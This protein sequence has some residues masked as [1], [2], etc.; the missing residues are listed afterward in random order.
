MECPDS[1]R[2]SF[3][4][5][6]KEAFAIGLLTKAEG[7]QVTSKQELHT[8]LK[9]AY[10]LTVVHKW[11]GAPPEVVAQA[12]LACKKALVN[13]YDFCHAENQ[14]RDILCAEIMQLVGQVKNLFGVELSFLNSDKGSFIPDSY[15]HIED[16]SVSFTLDGFAKVMQKFK[17]YHASLCDIPNS[18]CKA[19]EDTIDGARLCIT[20]LG[21]TI[22][23]LNTACNTKT[24]KVSKDIPIG[25]EQ[26]QR[27]SNSPAVNPELSTTVESTDALGSSWEKFS[28]S[29]TGSSWPST[30]GNTGSGANEVGTNVKNQSCMTTDVDDEES[31]SMLKFT[32]KNEKQDSH[33]LNSVASTHTVPRSAGPAT[34]SFNVSRD[35]EKFEAIQAETETVSTEEGW[36]NVGGEA[37][38]PPQ[39]L[40]QLTLRT[41]TSSLSD[42]FSSQSS[43]EKIS[44]DICS[45]TARKPQSSNLSNAGNGQIS[46]SPESDGSFFLV[47]T[48]DP[49]PS[50]ATRDITCKKP[51]SGWE[52]KASS[53]QQPLE[54]LNVDPNM[55]TEFDSV[56]VKPATKNSSAASHQNLFQC[57]PT[58]TSTESS[59]EMLEQNQSEHQ[60]KEVSSAE[61]VIVLQKK[62]PSCYSCLKHSIV[63]SV[64]P[65][66]QYL[67]SQEDYQ[68]LLAGICQD[69]LLNRLK[70]DTVQF[71]LKEHRMVYSEYDLIPFLLK[72][73]F[74]IH[75]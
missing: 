14:D 72:Y 56:S 73:A 19:P 13:F 74:S 15:R 23:T 58:E 64:V 6:A 61:K 21:T 28:L 57:A 12:T 37:Q 66:Q 2:P 42:S 32:D 67:L 41:S 36:T 71:K 68:A 1:Q 30:N 50:D 24:C 65:E 3:L 35:S 16:I 25:E 7:E 8:F 34:S 75:L 46:K 47:K 22:G 31:D 48:L 5:L 43:W 27:G 11:L 45:P 52:S 20:A 40:S 69:C 60:H 70:S 39:S 59:F 38:R 29:G 4:L 62:N 63:D 55:T 26:Q 49:D 9:A 10:S 51:T 33:G 53:E 44:A 17:K 18:H 54:S